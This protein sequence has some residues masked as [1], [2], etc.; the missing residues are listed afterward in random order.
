[1]GRAEERPDMTP[2]LL[3]SALLATLGTLAHA[4][5][6][7]ITGAK[8]LLKAKGTSQKLSFS[9]KDRTLVGPTLGGGDDPTAAGGALEVLNPVSGETATMALPA[10]GWSANTSGTAFKYRNSAAPGGPSAV[11]AA[12]VRGARGL[13]VTARGTGVTLDAPAQGQI[14]VVLS[15]GTRR[16]CALFGGAAVLADQ[17]GRFT[18]KNA[19]AP[20]ECPTAVPPTTTSTS[21]T[22]TSSSTSSTTSTSSSSSSTSSSTSSTSST[23]TSTTLPG[24]CAPPAL[25]VGRIGFTLTPGTSECGGSGFVPPPAPPHSGMLFG[26]GSVAVADLGLGCL[27]FGGGGSGFP[28]AKLATGSTSYLD[29]SGLDPLTLAATLAAS[30]GNGPADCTRGAGPGRR[31]L[32]GGTGTDGAGACAT[33]TDCGLTGACQLEANCYFGPPLPIAA[34]GASSCIVNAFLT[35]ACGSASLVNAGQATL[36]AAVSSRV[37]LT[38]NPTSPC[39]RCVGGFC[40]AGARAGEACAGGVGAE[41]TSV[42]CPPAAA[43]FLAALPLSLAPLS[44]GTTTVTA[45]DGLFCENQRVP[46]AFGNGDVRAIQ[47]TGTPLAG[48]GTL[49]AMTLAGTSCLPPTGNQLID[50]VLDAPGPVTVSVPGTASVCL[51]PG[52]CL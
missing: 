44:T 19:P 8:L 42:D 10:S 32:N 24:G 35:D 33:D 41:Q 15:V 2:T 11:R 34:A 18:A 12:I 49:F 23:S 3:L 9:S 36:E 4:A 14:G 45:P 52:L 17:P 27:Y 1:M 20:G 47:Q 28:P 31:C 37:Y 50:L 21:S 6:Q 51:L 25:P 39:P 5:D 29:V 7:P 30:E 40:S 13:K 16:Y 48:G 38:G 22:S 46:G 26:E 43:T